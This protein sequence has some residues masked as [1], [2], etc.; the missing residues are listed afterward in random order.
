MN[1]IVFVLI[2]LC[3]SVVRAQTTTSSYVP[4]ADGTLLAVDVHH[5]DSE[6]KN[7]RS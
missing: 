6:A 2:L 4:V 7:L 1:K 3:S 5:Q